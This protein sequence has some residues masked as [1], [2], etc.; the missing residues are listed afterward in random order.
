MSVCVRE[1]ECACV[2]VC[3][4]LS[5]SDGVSTEHL[6]WHDRGILQ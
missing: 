4:C 5:V 3:V 2:C 1:R 6:D